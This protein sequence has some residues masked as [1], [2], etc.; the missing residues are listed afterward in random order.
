MSIAFFSYHCNYREHEPEYPEEEV[1]F[2]EAAVSV[3]EGLGSLR[4]RFQGL[5]MNGS[6]VS[7]LFEILGSHIN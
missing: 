4:Q 5:L 1:R 7:G 2:Q 3:Q 6:M